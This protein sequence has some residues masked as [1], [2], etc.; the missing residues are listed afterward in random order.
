MDDDD[1]RFYLAELRHYAK[2]HGLALWAYCLM[3]NHVHFI[4]VPATEQAL[5]QTFHDA[6]SV[7][8][9]YFNQRHDLGGHL[10]QGRFHSSVLDNAHLWAA[11]RY[12]ERNPVRAR[13]VDR[14]EAYAWS[15]ARAHCNGVNDKLL[16]DAFP[17]AG[18]IEDWGQWL[19]E[20]DAQATEAIRR[21]TRT[22]RPCGSFEFLEH[23]GQILGRVMTPGKPGRKPKNRM[24]K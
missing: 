23:L 13:I 9:L 18:V 24:P 3:S 12:V 19:S 20:Q 17:P 2:K 22:G 21:A 16:A 10:F 4:A 5:A 15:S 8:S 11:V 1:R 14:A 7:Y 6:H